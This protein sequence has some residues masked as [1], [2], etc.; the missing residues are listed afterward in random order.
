MSNFY[1]NTISGLLFP[2]GQRVVRVGE[3]GVTAI[4]EEAVYGEMAMVP[5]FRIQKGDQ[6]VEM[7]N[8]AHVETVEYSEIPKNDNE[9][10]F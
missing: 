4:A 6:I 7:I 9:I 5:W 1:H 10:P 2:H 3:N 8:A